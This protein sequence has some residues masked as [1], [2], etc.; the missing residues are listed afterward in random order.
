MRHNFGALWHGRKDAPV[1]YLS[2]NLTQ[3]VHAKWMKR[4]QF[5]PMQ[6]YVP[7][8]GM[9]VLLHCIRLYRL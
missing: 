6:L 7:D 9:R 3:A 5:T 4:H 8:G 2:P 1:G